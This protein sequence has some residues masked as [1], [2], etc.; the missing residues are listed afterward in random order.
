MKEYRSVTGKV[1]LRDAEEGETM[2]TISGYAAT[3]NSP[4][5]MGYYVEQIDSAAFNNADLSDV[6]SCFNHQLESLLSRNTGNE[7][8]LVLSIDE[9]GLRYEFKAKNDCAQECAKNIQLGFVK[10]SSFVFVADSE[11][12]EYDQV[13][14]DGRSMD[15]RTILGIRKV[16]ELGP[17]VF[18]AYEDTTAESIER[19]KEFRAKFEAA[20]PKKVVEPTGKELRESYLIEFKKNKIK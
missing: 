15:V 20:R 8:D 17:V 1:E 6:V 10:G 13:Q 18:P 5:D 11:S 12:T 3:F 4:T 19:S 7:G 14:P 16:Y 9:I 2:Q